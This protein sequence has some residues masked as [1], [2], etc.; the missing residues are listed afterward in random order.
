ES[1]L[2][3]Y[4]GTLKLWWQWNK[5]VN[6]NPYVGSVEKILKFLSERFSDGVGHSALNS[7]RAALSLLSNED[8]TNNRLISRFIKGSSKIRP[9]LPKYDS[10]WDVDPVL[11]KLATWFPLSELSL[12]KLTEKLVVLL[13]LGTAHRSQTLALINISNIMILESR[14][15]IR[16]PDKIKTSRPGA[17]QP[18]LKFPFFLNKP[19]LC[20]GKTLIQYLAVTKS[21]RGNIDS[22]FISV[23][24]PHKGVKSETISR[25]IRSTLEQLGVD[26]RFTAHS[27]R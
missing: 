15:E 22:L 4:N 26:K 6:E 23:H 10:T 19:E 12:K 1:T 5:Q 14:I 17:S 24:K 7:A 25:W 16:I 18:V 20:I 11:K 8:I 2:K 13:A 9:S 27:T 21:L 3:Q